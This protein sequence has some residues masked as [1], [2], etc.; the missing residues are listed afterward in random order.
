MRQGSLITL[1]TDWLNVPCYS[2]G[3]Q[4][5]IAI[6]Q[7]GFLGMAMWSPDEQVSQPIVKAV[8]DTADGF[9]VIPASIDD[10]LHS[11]SGE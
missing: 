3:E 4:T 10:V 9:L 5:D 2:D 8:L 11:S 6:G 1:S 7:R